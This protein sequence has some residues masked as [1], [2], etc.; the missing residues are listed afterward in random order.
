MA[1]CPWCVQVFTPSGRGRPPRYCSPRC[2]K[3]QFQRERTLKRQVERYRDLAANNLGPFRDYW[4]E[5][6]AEAADDLAAV[7][8]AAR[9]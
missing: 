7:Q 6:A 3:A 8:L 1:V 2:R 4:T 9:Q 5:K